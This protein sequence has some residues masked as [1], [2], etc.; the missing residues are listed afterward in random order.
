M[1]WLEDGLDPALECGRRNSL[2]EKSPFN[3]F[4][5]S[6]SWKLS[7]SSMRRAFCTLTSYIS[8]S[9]FCRRPPPMFST[10]TSLICASANSSRRPSMTL[11]FC[12]TSLELFR[13]SLP[14]ES[15]RC[16]EGG[17]NWPAS[18]LGD[19]DMLLRKLELRETFGLLPSSKF[20]RISRCAS[21]SF[22][23]CIAACISSSLVCVS[24]LS[25]VKA[26]RSL[27]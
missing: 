25:L 19:D 3:V 16:T 4:S 9:I 22:M 7:F 12:I 8:F 5:L 26:A 18:G 14:L 2:L 24:S 17:A 20:V 15:L 1:G 11:S 6:N 10:S 21:V 13:D 23:R 27:S